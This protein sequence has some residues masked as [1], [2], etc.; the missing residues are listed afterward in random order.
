LNPTISIVIPNWNG[1][2]HLTLCLPSIARQTLQPIETILI[3]N[4]S[5]DDSVSFVRQEYP[6]V[7]ILSLPTNR[8][9]AVAVNR[10]IESARGEFIAL[11]NNDIELDPRWLEVLVGLLS[12]DTRAGAATGKMVNF[13][14]RTVLD[15][16][17]DAMTRFGS[18]YTR[19]FGEPDDGRY[20]TREQVF[21]VCAGAAMFHRSLFD[22]VGTFDEDFIS[23][24]EDVDLAFRGQL[25]G[26]AFWYIPEAVCYHKR[27]ATGNIIRDFPVRMQERNL[28]LFYLKNFPFV[29]LVKQFPFIL[30]SRVRRMYRSTRAGYGRATA[31]G[32][33]EGLALVPRMLRKRGAVQRLRVVPITYINSL[34]RGKR[35]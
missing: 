26:F 9:F 6:W 7:T 12:T 1:I 8:G 10:G 32:F 30:A 33:L 22:R 4:G 5:T 19:G 2:T 28:T 35:T 18:P 20:N 24:Y 16:A 27:G 3:D 11:L 31:R 23:Y 15:G 13:F 29:I 25:A 14:D 34:M 21:G 17:G